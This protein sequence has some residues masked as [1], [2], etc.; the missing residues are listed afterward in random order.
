MLESRL[1]FTPTGQVLGRSDYLPFGE[2]LNQTGALPRQR[3]TGQQ[4]DPSTQLRSPRAGSRGEA[5][6]RM[7]AENVRGGADAL[8]G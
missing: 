8:V 6:P 5:A 2:S 3:F 1:V 4:R 7:K